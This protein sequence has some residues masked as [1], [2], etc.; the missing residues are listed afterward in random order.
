MTEGVLLA[1]TVSFLES[2]SK[3]ARYSWL[4]F[5]PFV[6]LILFYFLTGLYPNVSRINCIRVQLGLF[7]IWQNRFENFACVGW[8]LC[9]DLFRG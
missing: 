7:L 4:G 3:Y 5:F 2:P 8:H 9:P 6:Y 1:D